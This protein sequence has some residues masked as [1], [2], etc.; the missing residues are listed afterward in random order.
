VDSSESESPKEDVHNNASDEPK[1]GAASETPKS[2]AASDDLS[3]SEGTSIV[4]LSINL[5]IA[6]SSL[7]K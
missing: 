7:N 5:L 6:S 2:G 1:T 3:T 4:L